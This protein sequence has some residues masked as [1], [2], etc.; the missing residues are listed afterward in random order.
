MVVLR[1]G[2]PVG[3]AVSGEDGK[4][5]IDLPEGGTYT[6]QVEVETLPEGVAPRTEEAASREVEVRQG[7]DQPVLF[8]LTGAGGGAAVGKTLSRVLNLAAQ[9]VKVGA[10]I[11]I[12]SVGLSLVFGVT[13][14]I[15]F[16]H[17][18]LVV[19]GAVAAFYLH[20]G[21]GGE[22]L[23]LIAATLLAVGIG[24][25]IGA[26][27]ELGVFRPLRHR[28]AGLIS[29]LVISIGLSFFIRHLVL[30]YFGAG[31]RKY[32]D[33]AIQLTPVH[34]GPVTLPPRD[35]WVIVISLAVLAAVGTLLK[36][37]R[38]G[39]AM[40]AVADNRDLAES[41]GINVSRVILAVWVSGAALAALGGVFQGLTTGG[42]QWDMGFR[43]LLLMFAGVI[44]GG[45]G[46]AY[47]AMVGGLLIGFASEISTLWF[48]VEL[49]LVFAFLIL[50]AMLLFRPHGILGIPE[51]VG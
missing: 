18:E 24:G 21:P 15:N 31:V 20:V 12:T 33:Y 46:T 2:E 47:G 42:V 19:L 51:R 4:W 27:L 32:I 48:S 3:E 38:L 17:G 8:P 45:I 35:L 39:T 22:R 23:P 7:A 13:G 44:L 10:I 36:T 29:L 49:K 41:S 9:G 14:L 50:I 34:L 25:V 6:V 16:A 43:L 1:D 37:T 30:I 26:A 5:R 40:R 11:A 28:K